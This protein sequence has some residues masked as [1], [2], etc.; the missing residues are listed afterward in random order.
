MLALFDSYGKKT[1]ATGASQDV[2]RAVFLWLLTSVQAW[3][4]GGVLCAASVIWYVKTGTIKLFGARRP[5]T[6]FLSEQH[7]E[8]VHA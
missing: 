4:Q 2:A 6:V 3:V 7:K 1:L 5:A 8:W